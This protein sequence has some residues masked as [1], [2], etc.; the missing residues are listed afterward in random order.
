MFAVCCLAVRQ[1]EPPGVRQ[2]QDPFQPLN[3]RDG[4]LDVHAVLYLMPGSSIW[5]LA[6]APENLVMASRM[7]AEGL[8]DFDY[9]ITKLRNYQ[10]CCDCHFL[11]TA[12]APV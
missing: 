6:F 5:A 11:A 10:I 4:F 12:L 2:G 9:P 3:F 1:A 7:M 8:R